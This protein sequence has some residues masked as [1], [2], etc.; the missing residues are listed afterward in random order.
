MLSHS[1]DQSCPHSATWTNNS[2]RGSPAASNRIINFIKRLNIS[3]FSREVVPVRQILFQVFSLATVSLTWQMTEREIGSSVR[4]VPPTSS[5]QFQLLLFSEVLL[6]TLIITTSVT[7]ISTVP[8]SIDIIVSE[9]WSENKL[10]ETKIDCL[11]FVN[12]FQLHFCT[13]DMIYDLQEQGK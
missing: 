2:H 6:S 9:V 3:M 5:P 12:W 7:T 8:D 10:I 1:H 11:L 4:P 13:V